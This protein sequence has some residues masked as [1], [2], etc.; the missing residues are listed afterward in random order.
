MTEYILLNIIYYGLLN[1]KR[2]VNSIEF[3]CL[4]ASWFIT[5]F[6]CG[7]LVWGGF[8]GLTMVKGVEVAEA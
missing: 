1:Y 7:P 2:L 3:N 4:K 6:C 8:Y 5:V